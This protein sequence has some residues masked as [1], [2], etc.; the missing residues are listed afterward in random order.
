MPTG[1]RNPIIST[2]DIAIK[3]GGNAPH[4][5]VTSIALAVDNYE[6]AYYKDVTD[7][8]FVLSVNELSNYVNGNGLE[9]KRMP[10]KEAVSHSI[11]AGGLNTTTYWPYWLEMHSRVTPTAYVSRRK[12]ETSDVSPQTSAE[13]A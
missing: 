3:T 5:F 12:T 9:V 7:K 10:T 13:W 2:T 4:N 8:V 6:N 11:V 1:P